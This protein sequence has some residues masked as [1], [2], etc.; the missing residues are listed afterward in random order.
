MCGIVGF[1]N[2][3]DVFDKVFCALCS[4]QHRGSEGAGVIFSDEKGKEFLPNT[5]HRVSGPVMECRKNWPGAR[6]KK[7]LIGIGHNRYGTSGSHLAITNLQPLCFDSRF[8][9][10]CIAHN[11]NIHDFEILKSE[12]MERGEIFLTNSDSEVL[13]KLISRNSANTLEEAIAATLKQIRGSFSVIVATPSEIFAA[14]DPWGNRP[15]HLGICGED[16][17]MVASEPCA[18]D[19]DVSGGKLHREIAKGELITISSRGVTGQIFAV[20]PV[21]QQCVFEI[22]YFSYPDGKIFGKNVIDFR[23]DLGAWLAKEC[24]LGNED[25]MV[26]TGIPDSSLDIAEGFAK[27]ANLRTS[28][29]LIRHPMIDRV[30]TASPEE[31]EINSRLKHSQVTERIRGKTVVL[32]DDSLVRGTTMRRIV[33]KMRRCGAKKVIVLIASPQIVSKCRYGIDMRGDLI[34]DKFRG[35]TDQICTEIGADKLIYLSIDGLKQV[36][37][38]HTDFCFACF[39]GD[40]KI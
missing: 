35:N 2:V 27:V 10:F 38:N 3:P 25:D 22:I 19:F 24:G 39:T 9:K 20:S 23:E 7:A 4:L 36:V 29:I 26:I 15:L 6:P 13:G 37:Q 5:P 31:R 33:E 40:Y 21:A 30:Y 32:I 14:R 17:F 12:L 34:A 1:F 28:R 16:G 18:F 11:G 8:G